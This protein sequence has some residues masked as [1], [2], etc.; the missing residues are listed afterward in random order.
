MSGQS[1]NQISLASAA[2]VKVSA[3]AFT[4]KYRSKWECYNLCAVDCGIYLP[5][6][7]KFFKFPYSN[8]WYGPAAAN[9]IEQVT[10]YFLKD[11][12]SGKKKKI[13]GKDVRHVAIP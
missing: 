9:L 3:S 7:G 5:A 2:K 11:L 13:Y 10:I 1:Q 8:S 6:Y 12:I 4:A